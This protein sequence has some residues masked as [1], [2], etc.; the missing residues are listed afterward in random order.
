VD[1]HQAVTVVL[2]MEQGQSPRPMDL[3][4]GVVDVPP[5][6]LAFAGWTLIS[7]LWQGSGQP[8]YRL[9]AEA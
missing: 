5:C 6:T 7:D 9:G 4:L 2:G 3:V 1:R 8:G